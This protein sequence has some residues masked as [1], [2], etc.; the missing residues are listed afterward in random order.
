MCGCGKTTTAWGGAQS[1]IG[2]VPTESMVRLAYR[3]AHALLVRGPVSGVGYA[4][5]PGET[6]QCFPQDVNALVA[7]GA[8]SLVAS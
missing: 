7:S 6:V 8:F 3:G 5:Y 4:C 1:D 2:T